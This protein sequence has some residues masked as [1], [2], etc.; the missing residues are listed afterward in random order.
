MSDEGGID[1]TRIVEG[2]MCVGGTLKVNDEHLGC[3]G[4]LVKVSVLVQG[5]SNEEQCMEDPSP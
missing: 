2:D 5:S 4:L 1:A 3:C